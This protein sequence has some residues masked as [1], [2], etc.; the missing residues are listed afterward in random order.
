MVAAPT[1]PP[2]ASTAPTTPPAAVRLPAPAGALSLRRPAR[3]GWLLVLARPWADVTVDGRRVGETPLARIPLAPGSHGVVLTH[4]DYEP[5]TRKVDIRPG[6]V[7]RLP[8][9]LRQDG[10]KRR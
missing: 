3:Q 7:T 5:F 9:R 6:E 2:V 10:V 8:L 4:P 1:P